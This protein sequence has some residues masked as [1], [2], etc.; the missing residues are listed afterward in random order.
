MHL[1]A[2]CPTGADMTANTPTIVT[3]AIYLLGMFLIGWM[4]YRA[5]SS[6]SDASWAAAVLARS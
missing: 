1:I 5:T 4:G 2:R 6:L 3:F